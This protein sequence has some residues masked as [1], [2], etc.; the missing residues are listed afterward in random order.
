M[1]PQQCGFD[2]PAWCAG[3]ELPCAWRH[4]ATVGAGWDVGQLRADRRGADLGARADA[5][6]P[7]RSVSSSSAADSRRKAARAANNAASGPRPRDVRRIQAALF[8][9]SCVGRHGVVMWKKVRGRA[10]VQPQAAWH[11]RTPAGAAH[12]SWRRRHGQDRPRRSFVFR[13]RPVRAK[14]CAAADAVAF[15]FGEA[16][17]DLLVRGLRGATVLQRTTIA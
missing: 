10:E 8:L 16:S 2:S 14:S 13:R 3:R 9:P 5:A 6:G 17:G 15:G 4:R 1:S 11:G 12:G 7:A